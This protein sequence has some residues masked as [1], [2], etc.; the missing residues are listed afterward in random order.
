MEEF[1]NEQIDLHK[2]PSIEDI[3]YVG[4]D[5][6]YLTVNLIS[7]TIFW[8]IFG[9]A[10]FI[11]LYFNIWDLPSWLNSL[12]GSVVAIIIILSY[13]SVNLGFKKKKYA[14]REKDVV[15]QTG[16]LWRKLTVLPF[17]RIQHAE[18]EQGPIER[19]FELSKLKIYTAGG[20]SSDL[21]IGG[22]SPE[23]A[24]AMKFYILRQT[25]ID[26]EE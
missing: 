11:F 19:L 1:S 10:A 4:L 15:Y 26:E 13:I 24:Q 17:N 12:I 16:L 23:R 20:A 21:N 8:V 2:L 3:D 14:L 9:S 6:N 5:K 25:A 18:V 22:I 7:L